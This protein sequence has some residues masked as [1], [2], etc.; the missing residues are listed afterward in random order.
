MLQGFVANVLLHCISQ[1]NQQFSF[2]FC[3][4]VSYAQCAKYLWDPQKIFRL[5]MPIAL[6]RLHLK[7]DYLRRSTAR[8]S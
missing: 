1:R 6:C 7:G 8:T 5:I 4:K 2:G 3:R